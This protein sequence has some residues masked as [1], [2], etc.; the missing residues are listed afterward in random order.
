[1]LA[2]KHELKFWC[3]TQ[4]YL[5]GWKSRLEKFGHAFGIDIKQ[6]ISDENCITSRDLRS[7]LHLDLQNGRNYVGFDVGSGTSGIGYA[8]RTHNISSVALDPLMPSYR[9]MPFYK[10]RIFNRSKN[11]FLCKAVGENIPF[12]T[13]S[14][15]FGF[16]L[17]VL[18]HCSNPERVLEEISRVFKNNGVLVLEVDV[19][20]RKNILLMMDPSHPFKFEVKELIDLVHRCNFEIIEQKTITIKSNPADMMLMI[21]N[22]LPKNLRSQHKEVLLVLR[23]SKANA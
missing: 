12:K 10:E 4:P 2:Q 22:F 17:N 16:C 18:D 1:M 23:K 19:W 3:E 14:C 11:A 6:P 9:E 5:Y 21:Q 7:L 20:E 13:E 8:I 15:D